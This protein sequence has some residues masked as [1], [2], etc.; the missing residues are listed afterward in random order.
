MARCRKKGKTKYLTSTIL[1]SPSVKPSLDRNEAELTRG[2]ELLCLVLSAL[3]VLQE[4]G[5]D[6]SCLR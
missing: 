6:T 2:S 5:V 1:Q 4:K 3:G